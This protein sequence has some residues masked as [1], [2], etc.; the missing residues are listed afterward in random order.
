L[1]ADPQALDDSFDA[2]L[3]S[4][5]STLAQLRASGTTVMK[6][7]LDVPAAAAW[8]SKQGRSFDSAARAAYIAITAREKAS[9]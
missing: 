1:A 3:S 4:A 5:E 8:A 7:S 9:Q 6:L 2:W